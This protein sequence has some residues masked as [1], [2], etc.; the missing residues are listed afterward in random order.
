[1]QRRRVRS[2]D[3]RLGVEAPVR[4]QRLAPARAKRRA[5]NTKTVMPRSDTLPSCTDL[6]WVQ[7]VVLLLAAILVRFR[8]LSLDLISPDLLLSL[9]E[10]NPYAPP[11]G[12]LGQR[13]RCPKRPQ[14]ARRSFGGASVVQR[15]ASSCGASPRV[16]TASRAGLLLR[17]RLNLQNNRL[18]AGPHRPGRS[19][20]RGGE[21]CL[22]ARGR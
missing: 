6:Q 7:P 4:R 9:P 19:G 5:T 13:P 2:I 12:R 20:C 11:T 18:R 10:R 3:A 8:R 14:Q 21:A 15:A 22:T 16:P 1:M 17:L